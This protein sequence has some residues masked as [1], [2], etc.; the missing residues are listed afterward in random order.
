MRKIPLWKG[1]YVYIQYWRA[2]SLH[3]F[4]FK[5]ATCHIKCMIGQIKLVQ[6][7]NNFVQRQNNFVQSQYKLVQNHFN[8]VQSQ[9]IFDRRQIKLVK[10]QIQYCRQDVKIGQ[11]QI[12]LRLTRL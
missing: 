9:N 7:Q 2:S 5:F 3:H 6:S 12:I 4:Y 1:T 10:Y 8:C 11:M